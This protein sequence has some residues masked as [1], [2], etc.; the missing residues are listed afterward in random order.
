MDSA[1]GANEVRS[2]TMRR[3]L[4]AFNAI[5]YGVN[6]LRNVLSDVSSSTSGPSVALTWPSFLGQLLHEFVSELHAEGKVRFVGMLHLPQPEGIKNADIE[7]PPHQSRPALAALP[8]WQVG[9]VQLID[10]VHGAGVMEVV[11]DGLRTAQLID[12]AIVAPALHG[13]ELLGINVVV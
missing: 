1:L 2:H 11:A 10:H 12:S 6:T 9:V 3:L 7:Q 5:S 13:S 8:A 4:T